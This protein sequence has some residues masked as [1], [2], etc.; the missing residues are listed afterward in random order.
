MPTPIIPPVSLAFGAPT[1]AYPQVIDHGPGEIW[2]QSPYPVTISASG[3]AQVVRGD[4]GSPFIFISLRPSFGLGGGLQNTRD[5][6]F[7]L[8][9][10]TTSVAPI[11]GTT[12][13]DQ[14]FV[15]LSSINDVNY[16]FETGITIG[17]SIGI[18]GTY[19]QKKGAGVEVGADVTFSYSST[20]TSSVDVEDVGVNA[21]LQS[22][23][24]TWIATTSNVYDGAKPVPYDVANPQAAL[25]KQPGNY[26]LRP[27]AASA[28]TFQM[29]SQGIWQLPVAA[30]GRV[31]FGVALQARLIQGHTQMSWGNTSYTWVCPARSYVVVDLD[32]ATITV[33]QFDP[34]WMVFES[35]LAGVFHSDGEKK[36]I[37][38]GP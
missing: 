9:T 23:G 15:P 5:D 12:L 14:Q 17:G 21:Q 25:R 22:A 33:T 38:G 28:G 32:A 37:D 24:M 11:S 20:E 26:Y 35:I 3:Q 18:K 10:L 6:V 7:L 4:D 30:S 27:P 13:V 16:S 34:E 36:R 31:V 2:R 19:S 29:P 1:V 8:D